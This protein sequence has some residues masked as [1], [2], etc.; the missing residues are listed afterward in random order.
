M[1]LSAADSLSSRNVTNERLI[2]LN[3]GLFKAFSQIKSLKNRNY[4]KLS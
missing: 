3:E 1:D 2:K 4:Y